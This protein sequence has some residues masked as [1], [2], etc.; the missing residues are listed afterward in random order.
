MAAA[1]AMAA[2]AMAILV[3]AACKAS[4][5]VHPHMPAHPNAPGGKQ[6]LV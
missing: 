2:V 5:P 6:K 1:V 4:S 3:K